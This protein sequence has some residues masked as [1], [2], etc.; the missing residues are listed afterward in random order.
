VIKQRYKI[1]TAITKKPTASSGFLNVAEEERFELSDGVNRRWFSRPVHSAALPPLRNGAYNKEINLKS[2]ALF[3]L[4]FKF[5]PFS[6]LPLLLH[7]NPHYIC[8]PS[9]HSLIV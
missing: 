4:Y 1:K 3:T 5:T 2:Q 8:T 6:E 7:R 9:R